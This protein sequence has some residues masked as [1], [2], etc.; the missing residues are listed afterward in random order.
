MSTWLKKMSEFRTPKVGSSS[1]RAS[2]T[3]LRYVSRHVA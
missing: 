2:T 1:I 3:S